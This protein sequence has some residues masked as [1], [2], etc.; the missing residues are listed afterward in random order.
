MSLWFVE[1]SRNASRGCVSLREEELRD[2]TQQ[3]LRRKPRFSR[4]GLPRLFS[5]TFEQLLGLQQLFTVLTTSSKFCLSEQSKIYRG[6]YTVAR[7]YE[8]YVRVTRTISHE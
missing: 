2:D 4:L 5:A 7:R 1:L 3:R 8:F 6:Y